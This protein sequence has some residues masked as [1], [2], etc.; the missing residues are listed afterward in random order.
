MVKQFESYL[1]SFTRREFWRVDSFC[2]VLPIPVM[3][4]CSYV[5]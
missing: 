2:S 5:N 1:D 3:C 4:A